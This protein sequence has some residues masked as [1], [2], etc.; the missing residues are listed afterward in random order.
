MLLAATKATFKFEFGH[1]FIRAE[2]Q[3]SNQNDLVLETFEKNFLTPS[4]T[5]ATTTFPI[6]PF[7]GV[8][9][10]DSKPYTHIE[11]ELSTVVKY[12]TMR[13]KNMQTTRGVQFP[14]DQDAFSLLK[15]FANNK[16]NFIQL[17]VDTLNEAIKLESYETNLGVE[18]LSDKLSK[19]K[20]KYSLFRFDEFTNKPVCK[21]KIL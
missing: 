19:Q 16:I 5:T 21:F 17:S 1:S 10:D 7:G 4:Q 3:V 12:P 20:P 2:Y 8:T 6:I 11:R 15:L 9:V 18:D 13:L 14:I